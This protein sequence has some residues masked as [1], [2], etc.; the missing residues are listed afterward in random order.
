MNEANKSSKRA[1]II[2]RSRVWG[3]RVRA[4]QAF[5]TR[6]PVG[7]IWMS[8]RISCR[9]FLD[10]LASFDVTAGARK[11]IRIGVERLQPVALHDFVR[12]RSQPFE[13]IEF[14]RIHQDFQADSPRARALR[15][16]RK[17][18]SVVRCASSSRPRYFRPAGASLE[19][20]FR[21]KHHIVSGF[22]ML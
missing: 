22:G 4:V 7:K 11:Q 19:L 2:R 14:L 18:A 8:W 10:S 13:L 3:P 20:I 9:L 5:E 12:C 16:P 15:N 6:H 1:Q 21:N 17:G